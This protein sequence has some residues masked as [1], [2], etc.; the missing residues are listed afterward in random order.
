M[1]KNKKMSRVK[2]LSRF[3]WDMMIRFLAALGMT[4]GRAE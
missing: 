3:M 4:G 1:F 2:R